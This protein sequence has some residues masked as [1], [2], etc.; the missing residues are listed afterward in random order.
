MLIDFSQ[1][2]LQDNGN[3]I[4][5]KKTITTLSVDEDGKPMTDVNYVPGVL[6]LGDCCREALMKGMTKISIQDT[7]FRYKLRN[8]IKEDVEVELSE[9]EIDELKNLVNDRY[10]LFLAGQL[11]TMLGEE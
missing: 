10:E 11:L 8:K 9:S 1:K 5:S 2:P 6:T 4:V 7:M 3:E